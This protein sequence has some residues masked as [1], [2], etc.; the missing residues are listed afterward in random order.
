MDLPVGEVAAAMLHLGLLGVVFGAL[1]LVVGAA[2]G[3]LGLSRGLPAAVAVVAYVVNGL[4]GFVSWLGPFQKLSPFY[5]Y[6]A[7]DPLRNG[8]SAVGVGVAVVTIV[9]LAGASVWS[10]ERRDVAG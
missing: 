8:I 5:Q 3:R 10:F 1:S 4:G 9:V 2:T 6:A 7:H